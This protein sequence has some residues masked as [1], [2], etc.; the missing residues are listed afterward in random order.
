MALLTLFAPALV[1][2]ASLAEPQISPEDR[3]DPGYETETPAPLP[4]PPQVTAGVTQVAPAPAE[5]PPIAGIQF[6]GADVPA[7]VAA[8]SQKFLGRPADTPTL[9][10]LAAAMSAA[11]KKSSVALFTLAIPS[12][13]LS[14][15]VVDVYIAEGRIAEI[16]VLEDGEVVERPLLRGF[17]EPVL[18][19]TPASRAAFER[20]IVLARKTEG[21]TVSPRL[22]TVPSMPGA[23]VIVLDTEKKKN[24]IAAGFDS[25]E[26]RLIESGRVSL[27]GFAFGT[28]RPGDALRGRF[29]ATPDLEQS[30]SANVQYST[31]IG[32]DGLTLS[33]AGVYQETRPSSVDIKGDASI[34]SA[35]LAYPVVLDFKKELTLNATV[36]RLEST[37]TALGSV[38]ANERISAARLGAKAGWTGTKQSVAANILYS[39]GLDFG[40]ARSSVPG[41]ETGF[42]KLTGTGQFVQVLGKSLFLRMK[43]KGQW[44]EDV[45][46]ANERLLI[47]G[48]EFGRGFDNGLVGFD[49][50]YA[51]SI[52]PAW[53][54][55]KDGPFKRSEIYVFA[56]HADGDVTG[57]GGRPIDL[58]LSSAGAGVRIGYKDYAM[59][60]V[61]VAE[62]VN[63]P[64]PGLSDDSI[65][66]LSWSIKYQPE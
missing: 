23:A 63:Q 9:T 25:R 16:L 58:D 66:T 51:A 61:E 42:N 34:L 22:K 47:G 17:L 52:E 15:G 14:D 5:A 13:D 11:Y 40:G 21:V 45:L 18:E 35:S 57:P 4:S 33:V 12:Q 55:L 49:K 56:D 39:R 24:G 19:E 43:A 59:V 46:P 41:G 60:G 64:V 54:P 65:V 26:S 10:E 28:F 29:S 31:P 38:I 7:N 30:R 62:P 44:T 32:T 2:P 1:A 27:S 3:L 8:A 6:K 48:T 37:N 36:D 20:G 50:G 53:R